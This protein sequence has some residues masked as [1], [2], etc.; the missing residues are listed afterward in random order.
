MSAPCHVNSQMIS[1]NPKVEYPY[2]F[3]PQTGY[4][5]AQTWDPA[6]D[7]GGKCQQQSDAVDGL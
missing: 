3:P 5:N 1:Q 7:G 6:P 2:Q 4:F